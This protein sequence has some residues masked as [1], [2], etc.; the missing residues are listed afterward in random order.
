MGRPSGAIA[1]ETC[2]KEAP[3]STARIA[4][5]SKYP[6]SLFTTNP[7]ESEVITA[8][9]LRFLATFMAVATAWSEDL[10]ALTTS[11]SGITATGLK[12]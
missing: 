10:G 8:V 1:S 3:S 5:P 6:S 9:F 11:T 12:K 7:A 4:S 2:S